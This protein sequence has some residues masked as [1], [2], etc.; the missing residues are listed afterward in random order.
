VTGVPKP[1]AI[2]LISQ[3]EVPR[4]PFTG[5]IGVIT[6]QMLDF[7]VVIRSLYVEYE[8]AYLWAGAGIVTDSTAEREWEETKD[9]MRPQAEILEGKV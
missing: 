5:S 2:E 7:S 6:R 1:R 3:L 8:Y 4:G 9:K